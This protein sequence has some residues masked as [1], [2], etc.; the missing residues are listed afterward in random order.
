M[1]QSLL[2]CLGHL[3]SSWIILFNFLFY[4]CLSSLDAR[5][6][7]EEERKIVDK[8]TFLIDRKRLMS[9]FFLYFDF[10][11][12]AGA[13]GATASAGAA[14]FFDFITMATMRCSSIK[15][16]RTIL[17]RSRMCSWRR[18]RRQNK[19]GHSVITEGGP[20]GR[21][22]NLHKHARLFSIAWSNAYVAWDE[23][24]WSKYFRSMSTIDGR[25]KERWTYAW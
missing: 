5:V 19:N 11:L 23:Q 6:D 8:Q 25:E 13:V 12:V 21:F 15:K 18:S 17:E 2:I 22:A 9:V 1:R 7:V 24:L 3:Q 16:A 20:L 14:P 4:S 10:W